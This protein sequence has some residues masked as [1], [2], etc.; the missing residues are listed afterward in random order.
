MANELA[1]VL[2][3][4][5]ANSIVTTALAA[6]RHRVVMIHAERYERPSP[7]LTAFERQVEHFK[8]ERAQTIVLPAAPPVEPSA[9]VADRLA[10]LLP[11]MGVG[12]RLA[13]KAD[14]AALYLGLSVSDTNGLVTAQEFTQLWGDLLR[15]VCGG[16]CNVETPLIDLNTTQIAELA[17]QVDAPMELS[18]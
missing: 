13:A 14:A 12:A 18:A 8:P 16:Q 2:C 3:S 1:I 11:L 5:G 10:D 9:N 4:G 7:Q 15:H 17:A 6:Q